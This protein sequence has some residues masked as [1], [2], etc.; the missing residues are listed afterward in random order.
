MCWRR[1][2][3]RCPVR[4][5]GAVTR[6]P[7]ALVARYRGDASEA[8]HAYFGHLWSLVRPAL[9]GRDGRTPTNLADLM[10]LTPREK[11]KLLLFTAALLA[12]RRLA[13]GLKLNY[14]EAVALISA[15]I[16]EGARD[17]RTRGRTHGRGHDD[18]VACAGDGGRSRDD[19]RYPGRSD[20]SRRDQARHRASPHPMKPGELLVDAG[21]I[22]LN[23]GRRTLT[24][25]VANTGDR[26]VQIGSH[27]HFAETNAALAFDRAAAR[28]FRLNIAAGTAVRFEPGQKRT[29]EL[30]AYA[31]DRIVHGF[32][33]EVNGPLERIAGKKA[34]KAATKAAKRAEREERPS[35]QDRRRRR[36]GEEGG[37]GEDGRPPAPSGAPADEDRQACL[38]RDVRSHRRR[39]RASRRHRPRRR[40]R[41][42]PH[43][44]TARR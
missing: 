22:E 36:Y 23:A 35:S 4:G 41:A 43:R 10:E 30:V 15:A 14:P 9:L 16:L 17:G 44:S 18:P 42:R 20:V 6:L 32:L 33:G 27:Y 3:P 5:E 1:A 2:A 12:E 26:P 40:G 25:A 34:A 39:S 11:D 29:V 8:G 28:G 37:R 31:G 13:R 21:Q 7:D 24:L 38:C 19:S